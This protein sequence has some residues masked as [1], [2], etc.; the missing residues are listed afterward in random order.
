M[1]TLERVVNIGEG[2]E[3]MFDNLTPDDGIPFSVAIM[4]LSYKITYERK[5]RGPAYFDPPDETQKTIMFYGVNPHI[6]KDAAVI[7]SLAMHAQMKYTPAPL[8]TE[9]EFLWENYGIVKK[10]RQERKMK[11]AQV[12]LAA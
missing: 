11:P 9:A 8:T 5:N 4:G 6:D 3:V 10:S 2:Q 7:R 1:D 12:Q